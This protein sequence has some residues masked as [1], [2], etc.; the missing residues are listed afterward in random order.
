MPKRK[1]DGTVYG[2]KPAG[3]REQI[4][5]KIVDQ[6]IVYCKKLLHK[7]LKT[8]KGFTRQRLATRARLAADEGAEGEA[9]LKKLEREIDVLKVVLST[10]S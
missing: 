2:R 7:A 5:K 3:D 8:A 9:E 1:R 4:K 6:K 10:F